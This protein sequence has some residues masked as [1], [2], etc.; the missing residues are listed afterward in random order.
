MSYQPYLI[1]QF[2][3]G[4]DTE[5][6][7]W[8]LPQD[9]FQVLL[10]GFIEHG[11]VSKRAGMEFFGRMVY[12]N[13]PAP[14]NPIM[15]IKTFVDTN[16]TLQLL[17]FDTKRAAI[18]NTGTEEFD[19][20]DTA[21]IFDG[22]PSSFISGVGYG[23]TKAFSTS[24]YFFTNFN[25]DI[26]L[27]ISS[28]RQ[29][30]TGA[31]TS[32]FVP[33]TNPD[34]ISNYVIAAQ[35]IFAFRE[36]LVVLNTVESTTFPAGTP[37]VGTGTNYAQRMRWSRPLNPAASGDN[38]NEVKPGNGGFVDAPTSDQIVSAKQLQD[39][40]LVFFTNSVWAIEPV[41]D[42]AQPFRW[43]K[44]NS[45][46][47]CDAPYS[48]IAH[49]RF[50][51]GFGKRGIA[52]CDRV[53]VQR[54]DH[55]IDNFMMTQV[56]ATFYDRMYSE[57][58]YTNRRSFT[59]FPSGI[60]N[61]NPEQEAETS[62]YALIR[63]D[64]EGAWSIYSV[65]TTDLDETNGT[66]L[67]CLGYAEVSQDLA[68][69]DFTGDRDFSFE[70]FDD[71]TWQSYFFQ[72]NTEIF[73]GGDQS[74]R[75]LMLES[76]GDDMGADIAFEL[77][78]AGWNPYKEEGIQAQMGYVD[79]YVDADMDTEFTV[80]FFA[81]DIDFPYTSQTL[82]CL[83][84]LG[85]IADIIN[86]TLSNPVQIEAPSNGLQTGEQIYIYNVKGAGDVSG[87]PYT[88][89]V[90]DEDNFTLDG[91]DGTAFQAYVSGGQ[92]VRRPF[93]NTKCWKRAYAGGKGYQHYIKI[94][95]T[96]TNDVLNFSGFMPWFRPS[97]KRIIG[98]G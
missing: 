86:V 45:Y 70:D 58:N 46:R 4:V 95:N 41:S 38:W 25:G 97:G 15:G 96:G 30:T 93:Q 90:I 59:L 9:A 18:Y 33:N 7:P 42:P 28:M 76:G 32:V 26:A 12:D 92:I 10:N 24:T 68:F 54:I 56:N 6:Q 84:N 64:E 73:L 80:D 40:I 29:F 21:D 16:N 1:S 47:A 37:P 19:P 51:I 85:F 82:N 43:T 60:E 2:R 39:V 48:T 8:I 57:R 66:N 77:Q 62:N 55:K 50:S 72:D 79:F 69:D 44:I 35:F 17:I 74:G 67:S 36:R 94:T 75:I 22:T 81:D 98:G 13:D 49:D 34:G 27:P 53:E 63:T 61:L 3:T 87:G 52:A 14:T 65:Y 83:P 91:I 71:E 20:L 31:T 11:M 5:V 89:T 78:S 88:V 23:K